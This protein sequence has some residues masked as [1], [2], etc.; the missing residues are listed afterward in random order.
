[1]MTLRRGD[2]GSFVLFLQERLNFHGFYTSQS[3]EFKI[4]T[5]RTLMEFQVLWNL[6]VTG[7][8]DDVVWGCLLGMGGWSRGGYFERRRLPELLLERLGREEGVSVDVLGLVGE[9]LRYLGCEEYPFGR[10]KGKEV[11]DL[12]QGSYVT[13]ECRLLGSAY[14]RHCGFGNLKYF[15]LWSVIGLS[16]IFAQYFE[17]RDW[18]DA[19]FGDW[20]GTVD[21]LLSWG[22]VNGVLRVGDFG[23]IRA[24]EIFV[25]GLAGVDY[26]VDG[27]SYDEGC[28]PRGGHCGLVLWESGDGFVQTLECNSGN[29]VRVR[30]RSVSSFLGV[31]N[32]EGALEGLGYE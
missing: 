12:V 10:N 11:C 23:V 29:G 13:G 8:C 18:A 31:I 28:R 7:V 9:G 22:E 17:A 16:S 24:G 21:Q 5:E 1:M 2:K 26:F 25:I 15:P 6:G 32:W 14:K 19:P 20:F 4:G 3:G 27:F 30:S